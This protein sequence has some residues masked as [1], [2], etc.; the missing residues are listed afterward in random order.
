MHAI[1]IYTYGKEYN[2]VGY[3]TVLCRN[4]LCKILLWTLASIMITVWL[5]FT[6]CIH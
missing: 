6:N 4:V 2:Y 5:T 3:S 1:K